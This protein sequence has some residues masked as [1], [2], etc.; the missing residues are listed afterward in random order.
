MF[1]V[2]CGYPGS[3]KST[4]VDILK[5][6]FH[7]LGHRMYVVRPS[8]W[9][10]ENIEE[11]DP[12]ERTDWQI[13]SWEHA[14]DKVGD[15]LVTKGVEN[16]VLLDTCGASP[17]SISSNIAVAE[18][19]RHQTAAIWMAVPRGICESRVDPNIVAKYI[20][21]IKSAV[22]EYNEKFDRFIV[23]KHGTIDQ[24]KEMAVEAAG[25]LCQTD[26][27]LRAHK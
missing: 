11:M 2:M 18:M 5:P 1:V 14:L 9:Y 3:G 13:G 4:F 20:G 15:L 27:V 6:E 16:A 22:L 24:W 10:P 12:K 7:K 23:V 26:L 21:R 19:R 8:D 17:K 25:K